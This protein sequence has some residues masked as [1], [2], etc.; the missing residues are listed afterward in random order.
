MREYTAEEGFA[1]IPPGLYVIHWKEHAGPGTSLAAVGVR[2]DGGRWL[3]STEWP[4]AVHLG[5]GGVAKAVYLDIDALLAMRAEHALMAQAFSDLCQD[6]APDKVRVAYHRGHEDGYLQGVGHER[7]EC[8]RL[9]EAEFD[10]A[11]MW[12]N[13]KD[14]GTALAQAIR[15]RTTTT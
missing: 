8:A 4:S 15:A 6:E 1:N 5:W 2:D 3:A 13:V 14:G 11:R 7:E 12:E 10:E 9:V